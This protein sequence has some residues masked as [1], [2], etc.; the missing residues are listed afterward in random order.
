MNVTKVSKEE[1]HWGEWFM[2][3]TK[4]SKKEPHWGEW[5]M[6]VTKVSSHPDYSL[7]IFVR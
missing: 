6:N 3:I 5:F 1:P 4:V 7:F 2:N